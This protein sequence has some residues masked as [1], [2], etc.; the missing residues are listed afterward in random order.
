MEP[1][2]RRVLLL[3]ARHA[4]PVSQ[5]LRAFLL[6]NGTE[7]FFAALRVAVDTCDEKNRCYIFLIAYNILHS[8][9]D[10][11][12]RHACE[13]RL[14]T[15]LRRYRRPH[16]KPS[17]TCGLEHLLGSLRPRCDATADHVLFTMLLESLLDGFSRGLQGDCSHQ[18]CH[19]FRKMKLDSF[20]DIY[21]C[22]NY[23]ENLLDSPTLLKT[24]WGFLPLFALLETV[25]NCPLITSDWIVER[26]SH[27]VDTYHSKKT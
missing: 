7:D 21:L 9:D 13:R 19:Q 22:L 1:L 11:D 10:E 18:Q 16:H 4:T 5:D 14:F 17:S 27:L 2:R 25:A 3:I 12:E 15:L 24:P 26:I 8:I 23:L 6:K 20:F